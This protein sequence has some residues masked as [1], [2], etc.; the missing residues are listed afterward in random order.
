[1]QHVSDINRIEKSQASGDGCINV[2]NMLSI[3]EVKLNLINCDIKFVS[4]SSTI[5]MRRGPIY[6]RYRYVFI[7]QVHYFIFVLFLLDDSQAPEFYVQ[8]FRCLVATEKKECN[9]H[10]TEKI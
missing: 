9:I 6:I 10:N 8:I 7:S 3:E 5:T 1:V 4:Y 2:R